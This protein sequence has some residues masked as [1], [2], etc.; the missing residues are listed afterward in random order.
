MQ[1]GMRFDQALGQVRAV[2]SVCGSVVGISSHRDPM[3]TEH[4]F[5]IDLLR[6]LSTAGR[7]VFEIGRLAFCSCASCSRN[8]AE[9]VRG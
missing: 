3:R 5:V 1:P 9:H 2:Q 8:A 6:A 4:R 7:S